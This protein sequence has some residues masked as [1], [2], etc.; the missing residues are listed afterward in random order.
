MNAALGANGLER[1]SVTQEGMII[2]LLVEAR[3]RGLCPDLAKT[4]TKVAVK[5]ST[6]PLIRSS[7][8]V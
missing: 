8:A 6:V 5:F 3:L 2:L 7:L 4:A 1:S